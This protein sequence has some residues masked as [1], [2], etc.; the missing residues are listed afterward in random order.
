[1]SGLIAP[2]FSWR[3]QT[4]FCSSYQDGKIEMTERKFLSVAVIAAAMLATPALA[5]NS[6][7]RL[8]HLAEDANAS[9]KSGT[10]YVGAGDGFRG[11][12]LG[13]AFGGTL[14]DRYGDRD[15]W[16]HWGAYYGPMIPSGAGG[17]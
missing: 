17:R 2:P 8:Q 4:L 16:G 12:H 3:S 11:N 1:M 6:R 13:G 9:T 14:G 7:V 15:V 5:R 10:R